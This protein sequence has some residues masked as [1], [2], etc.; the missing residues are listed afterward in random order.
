MKQILK[1]PI[2]YKVSFDA[3]RKDWSAIAEQVKA[4]ITGNSDLKLESRMDMM[5]LVRSA[6]LAFYI[7]GGDFR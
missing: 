4:A 5:K 1:D 6:K 3:D 2:I 7:L